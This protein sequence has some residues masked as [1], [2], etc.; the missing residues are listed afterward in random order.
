MEQGNSRS[1]LLSLVAS[2][3]IFGTIGIFRRHIPLPSSMIAMMRGLIGMLF[4]LAVLRFSG[5]KISR[6]AIRANAPMLLLSG[7]LLGFNW[8]LLFEAYRY[9]SVATATL[10]YYMAPIIVMLLSPV[11]LGEHLTKKKVLCVAVALAGM[12]LVSGVTEAGFSGGQEITG[13]LFGLGAAALYAGV[14]LTNKR[15]HDISAYDKTIMQLGTSAVLLAPYALLTGEM[16]AAGMKAGSAL[17][18]LLVGVVHTGV[19][20]WLY[21]G[22]MGSLRAQT[23]ALLSYIDPVVAIVLSALLLSESMTAAGAVGAVLVLG[24]TIASELKTQE[25]GK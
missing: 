12:V 3:V 7:A 19:A 5:R 1:A 9:T 16:S 25:E 22:C 21:F 15:I 18:L 17:L 6:A 20:Y 4:L 10:C 2:M 11:L 8:I 24:A 23:V 13:V 14:I